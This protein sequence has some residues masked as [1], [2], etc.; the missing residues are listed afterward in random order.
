VLTESQI[1]A[2][3]KEGETGMPVAELCRKQGISN[4]TYRQWKSKY[5]SRPTQNPRRRRAGSSSA[6]GTISEL[7]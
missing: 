4:A 1:V 5:S 3:L 2:V 7:L 6:Q